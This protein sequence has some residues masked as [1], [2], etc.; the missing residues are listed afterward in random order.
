M[1]HRKEFTCWI[2][3]VV[4]LV[5]KSKREGHSNNIVLECEVKSIVIR[6][7]EICYTCKVLRCRNNPKFDLK[8][9][10]VQLWFTEEN[11][12]TGKRGSVFLNPVFTDAMGC[13]RWIKQS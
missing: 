8:K 3:D 11:I 1:K 4:Y 6:N 10:V 7:E 9:I 13:I 5:Y 2:G 12:N